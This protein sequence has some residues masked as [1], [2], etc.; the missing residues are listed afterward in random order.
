[1]LF[2][3]FEEHLKK[4]AHTMQLNTDIIAKNK[5]IFDQYYPNNKKVFGYYLST[6]L[7]HLSNLGEKSVIYMLYDNSYTISIKDIKKYK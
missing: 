5:A 3:V 4:I 2:G 1:M 6:V 7:K